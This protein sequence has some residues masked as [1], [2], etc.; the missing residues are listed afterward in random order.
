MPGQAKSVTPQPRLPRRSDRLEPHYRKTVAETPV[1]RG[2]QEHKNV[3]RCI[4]EEIDAIG[5]KGNRSD[6]QRDGNLDA[7]IGKVERRD[8]CHGSRE[9]ALRA[10]RIALQDHTRFPSIAKHGPRLSLP[11]RSARRARRTGFCLADLRRI[12]TA[13]AIRRTAMYTVY[14]S[15]HMRISGQFE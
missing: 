10:T 15:L 1:V 14:R 13:M 4:F 9:R 6:G 5:E 8:D 7:E 2:V 12:R 3:E 11:C